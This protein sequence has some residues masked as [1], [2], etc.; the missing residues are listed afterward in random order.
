VAIVLPKFSRR[1]LSSGFAAEA[2]PAVNVTLCRE[3]GVYEA[4]GDLT[5]KWRIRRI[6]VDD[7]QSVEVS[8]MWHTEGKGD[9]DL[10]VHHF[11]RIG[12]SQI[13]RQGLADQ[14]SLHCKLPASPLSYHGHL[15]HLRWCL[16]LRLFL[17]DG[18]EILAEQPFHLVAPGAYPIDGTPADSKL[19]TR[20]LPANRVS[21]SSSKTSTLKNSRESR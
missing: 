5:A 13:R 19:V 16:R 15:I 8:V 10:H 18:R 12:E 9:E 21:A 7:I 1:R 6:S 2:Q 11:H 20:R 4:G 17:T 14:Q 3:D